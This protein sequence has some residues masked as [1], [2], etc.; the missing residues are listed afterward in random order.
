MTGKEFR[1]QL[2]RLFKK[3]ELDDIEIG[4]STVSILFVDD[5]NRNKLYNDDSLTR[6]ERD[7]IWKDRRQYMIGYDR[8]EDKLYAEDRKP[9]KEDRIY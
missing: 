1:K 6:E 5:I 4:V 2:K 3:L 7:R 8:N 9:V